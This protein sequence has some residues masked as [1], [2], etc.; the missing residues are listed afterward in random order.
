VEGTPGRISDEKA[1]HKELA[2][3][4]ARMKTATQK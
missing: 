4:I 1:L 2:A 3:Y